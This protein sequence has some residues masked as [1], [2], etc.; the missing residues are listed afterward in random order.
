M[1]KVKKMRTMLLFIVLLIGSGFAQSNETCMDCHDDEEMT[2][3]VK[4]TIEIS[5]YV[6]GY[7]QLSYKRSME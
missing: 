6:L 2:A 3:F 1:W 7:V 5:A 4:D